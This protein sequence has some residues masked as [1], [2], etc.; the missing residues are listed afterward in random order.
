MTRV[1]YEL[2]GQYEG[3]CYEQ[4]FQDLELYEEFESVTGEKLESYEFEPSKI[5][6]DPLI[7]KVLEEADEEYILYSDTIGLGNKMYYA[8]LKPKPK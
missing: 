3:F 7:H 4:M 6:E 1:D 5:T 2:L 8:V